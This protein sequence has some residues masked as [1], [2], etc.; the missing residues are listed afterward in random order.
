MEGKRK[1]LSLGITALSFTVICVTLIIVQPQ[2]ISIMEFLQWSATM[3]GAVHALFIG[4]NSL[5]HKYK[6]R[7]K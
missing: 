1:I 2:G 5:E 4:G 6:M 7:V 3:L